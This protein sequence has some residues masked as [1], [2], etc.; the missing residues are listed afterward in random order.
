MENEPTRRGMEM[1]ATTNIVLSLYA[2]CVDCLGLCIYDHLCVFVVIHLNIFS[3]LN[4]FY[5]ISHFY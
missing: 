2:D 5:L 4:M 1:Q 3:I